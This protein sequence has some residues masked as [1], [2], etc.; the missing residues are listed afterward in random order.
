MLPP[1]LPFSTGEL[2]PRTQRP[3]VQ[4]KSVPEHQRQSS[5]SMRSRPAGLRQSRHINLF[6]IQMIGV[7]EKHH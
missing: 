2:S 4:T 7:L 1:L 3:I 5:L 6:D